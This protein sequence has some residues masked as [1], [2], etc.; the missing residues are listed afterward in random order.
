MTNFKLKL[1]ELFAV[2]VT[3]STLILSHRV[4]SNF[5]SQQ[6]VYPTE[7]VYPVDDGSVI[8]LPFI[9]LHG[10]LIRHT[11]PGVPNYES[12]EDGDYPETRWVLEIPSKEIA[13]LIGLNYITENLYTP[14]E[15]GWIQLIAV[16][17]EESPQ[18]FINKQVIVKGY[19][20]T[21]ASHIHTPA[22]IEAKE[23]YEDLQKMD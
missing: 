7:F 2:L 9:T 21:L 5:D 6:V 18:S 20:G 14:Y 23:I 1:Y 3:V 11:F 13:R 16:D 17:T 19:L 4:G 12:I 15:E 10:K 8:P 22:T